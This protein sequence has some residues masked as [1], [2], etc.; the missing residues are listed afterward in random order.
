MSPITEDARVYLGQTEETYDAILNDSFSGTTPA[1]TLTTV[2]A[3]RQIYGLLNPGGMY[4]TNIIGSREWDGS[5]FLLAEAR[6][7][8]Q[9]FRYVYIVPCLEDRGSLEDASPSEVRNHMVIG[10]D[11]PLDIEGAVD[12]DYSSAVI[13][14]DDY[15]PVDALIP[16]VEG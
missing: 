11:E 9:I 16:D 8:S 13:L 14:T 15:N 4:L 3:V 12:A 7:I 1:E 5:G 10:S 2:E 6:T